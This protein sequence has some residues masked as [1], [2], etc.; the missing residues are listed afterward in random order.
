MSQRVL[1][2]TLV[3]QRTP[4]FKLDTDILQEGKLRQIAH[5]HGQ[6]EEMLR[7]R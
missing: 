6:Q 4:K 2:R 3:N 7:T 5:L 1:P